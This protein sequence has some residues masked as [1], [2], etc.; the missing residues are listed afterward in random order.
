MSK[1]PAGNIL[2]FPNF[3]LCKLNKSGQG[4]MCVPGARVSIVGIIP[5]PIHCLYTY[6]EA[7]HSVNV[8]DT[9]PP[10]TYIYVPIPQ[11]YNQMCNTNRS[12]SVS[13]IKVPPPPFNSYIQYI[14]YSVYLINIGISTFHV[15]LG[16]FQSLGNDGGNFNLGH[17]VHNTD[18]ICYFRIS[19]KFKKCK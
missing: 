15:F 16:L 4:V 7:P 6:L 14:Q 10:C 3:Q 12:Y 18:L 11:S 17:T 19:D 13:Q 2:I 9:W 8:S 5:H 1:Y